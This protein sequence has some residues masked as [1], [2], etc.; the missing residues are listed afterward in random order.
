MDFLLKNFSKVFI[1]IS[2]L[3]LFYVI[4]QSEIF[5][6]GTQRD[7]YLKYYFFSILLLIFS[8][9]SYF[10][11]DKIKRFLLTLSLCFFFKRLFI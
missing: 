5:W 8:G 3:I 9:I 10:L 4:F 1:L 7:Y 2:L 6:K 11:H